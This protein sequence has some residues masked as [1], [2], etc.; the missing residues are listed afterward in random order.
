MKNC[1]LQIFYTDDKGKVHAKP[2]GKI[3]KDESTGKWFYLADMTGQKLWHNYN[4][5]SIANQLLDA[6]SKVKIRP[7]I[8]YRRRDMASLFQTNM[9]AFRQKGIVVPYG[10]HSQTVLP[11][12]YWE[13]KSASRIK[14]PKNLPV[15]SVDK[16]VKPDMQYKF[17]DDGTMEEISI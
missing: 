14:E 16:W 6:F 10:S 8:F 1:V 4:G 9:S 7:Q 11:L 15:C 17:L 13:A 3:W 2:Q 12:R 5:Y